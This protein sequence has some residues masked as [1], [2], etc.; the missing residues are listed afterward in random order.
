[1]TS[2]A[3]SDNP[4]RRQV[5]V[6]AGI[7]AALALA[8]SF[9]GSENWVVLCA[10]LALFLFGMQCL[11]EGLRDLAGERLESA[12]ARGTSTRCKSLLIGIVGTTVLQSSTLVS[13]MTIAFITTGLIG[14]T[15]GIA[16]ILGANL[17]ATT[18][19]WLLALAGQNFSLSPLALPLV[20]FGVIASFFGPKAKAAGRILLGIAFIFLGIDQIKAGF[21]SVTDSL[22]LVQYE[23]EGWLGHLLFAGL[24]L[25]LT[26]VMQST[27][28][29]LMLTLAALALG[30][31]NLV[32]AAAIAIGANVGSSVTTGIAGA[33]G[34]NRSG[35]RLALTHVLFNVTSAVL[36]MLFITPLV[37]LTKW[38]A[39][40][41]GFG[42][43]ELIM[44]AI[45]HTL[46]NALGV[47]LFWPALGPFAQFLERVLPD[48]AEPDILIPD[49]PLPLAPADQVRA[50]YLNPQ[51]LQALDSAASAVVHELEHLARLSI[52]VI[53]HALYL[54]VEEIR[55]PQPDEALITARPGENALSADI[56]YQRY[57]KGVYSDLLSFM[58]RIDTAKD[59]EHR[60]FWVAC[61]LA[62][63]QLVEAVKDAKHL[64]KNLGF[65]LRQPDSTVRDAYVDLR[66]HLLT[67]LRDIRR[68]GQSGSSGEAFSDSLNKLEAKDVSFT[69]H[70]RE[71]LFSA[72]RADR[73]DGHQLSSVLNDLG[74]ASRIS[75]SLR[76]TL[77]LSH[78][79]GAH[80]R[81]IELLPEDGGPL[82]A[83][84]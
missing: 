22:E 2:A 72:I 56:L 32:Q 62:A 10:G 9:W 64:Q 81:E 17:G 3:T 60:E 16:I 61:Q 68:L 18:G 65:Y 40:V 27:H 48:R 76:S 36:A 54:P 37:L 15:A 8:Y 19:I 67:V 44:L 20:V 57:I 58:G 53:C 83:L 28:A 11:E 52:E 59:E 63:R 21:S 71:D 29:T 41:I 47:L 84:P 55:S 78:S 39:G 75:R 74:Y 31:V 12:L 46:F 7:I 82:I 4:L 43:N 23:I 51:A 79:E 50:R 80:L 73:I 26:L 33:L 77:A 45:F 24:G 35:Q 14:L 34:G 25:V 38:L 1:M 30:Q 49:I 5:T 70:I 13:L 69:T 66:R 6:L 42:G